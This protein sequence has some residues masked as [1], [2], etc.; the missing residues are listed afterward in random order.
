[1]N[2][3]AK[4]SKEVI[5]VKTTDK[6]SVIINCGDNCKVSVKGSGSHIPAI[7][8]TL[9]FITIAV[10]I[11]SFCCPELLADFVWWIIGEAIGS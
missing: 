2:M 1:M 6:P 9:G 5:S 3:R 7:V 8:I 4:N 10:L 11:L